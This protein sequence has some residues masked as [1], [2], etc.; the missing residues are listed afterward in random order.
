MDRQRGL[1]VVQSVAVGPDERLGRRPGSIPLARRRA[2]IDGAL[3]RF[4]GGVSER[5]VAPPDGVV[6]HRH[7]VE[8]VVAEALSEVPRPHPGHPLGRHRAHLVEAHLQKLA[9]HDGIEVRVVGAGSV[10]RHEKGNRL[11][12]V[13]DHR[14][15]VVEEHVVNGAAQRFGLL[16]GVA[17]GVHEDVF[18][19]VGR[20]LA[21]Q[22]IIVGLPFEIALEPVDHLVAPVGVRDGVD[23]HDE[24]LAHVADHGLL[25]D[26]ETVGELHDHVR[27]H[28]LV[29]VDR[30]VE[31]VDGSG[32]GEDA[33]R[34]L[35][36]SP[37]RV[38]EKGGRP[39]QFVE[40]ADPVFIGDGREEDLPVL[41][42][43][44]DHLHLYPG[45]SAGE[46]P[47]VAVDLGGAR[48]LARRAGDV[49][50]IIAWRWHRR[51]VGNVGDPG[52]QESGL[53][54]EA[55]DL[56]DRPRLGRIGRIRRLRLD[57]SGEREQEEN[58]GA[59]NNASA[60]GDGHGSF[61]DGRGRRGREDRGSGGFRKAWKDENPPQKGGP[62]SSRLV[63]SS[64]GFFRASSLRIQRRRSARSSGVSSRDSSASATRRSST[65][66]ST[67]PR[68]DRATARLSRNRPSAGRDSTAASQAGKTARASP[69]RLPYRQTSFR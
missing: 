5:L 29:G 10:P 54:G 28:A 12:E 3:D 23:Q 35:G 63:S 7:R 25:G 30:G 47:E 65:A 44:P 18:P 1:G 20:G 16:M 69:A 43:M 26:G 50:E 67:S 13:V 66:P 38:G 32:P 6:V 15:V 48:E 60:R 37:A 55:R 2:G 61:L 39:L 14:R 9:E 58:P 11:V 34:L 41:F 59:R 52:A 17:I 68:I 27:A 62:R 53:G 64:K 8:V 57:E 31:V 46:L 49:P 36:R 42:G 19:P 45:G 33:L 56:L 22:R 21:R 40:P 51:R 4:R 24:L